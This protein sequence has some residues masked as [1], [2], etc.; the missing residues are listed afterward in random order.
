MRTRR[1]PVPVKWS[2]TFFFS[3]P[4]EE[5]STCS[6]WARSSWTSFRRNR[7]PWMSM[8]A[9]LVMP[10]SVFRVRNSPAKSPLG[11]GG[12]FAASPR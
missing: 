1:L 7:M 9:M 11:P 8:S 6:A 10:A 12:A 5:D 4:C 3:M 2:T